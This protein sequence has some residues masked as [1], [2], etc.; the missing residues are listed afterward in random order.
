MHLSR[1]ECRPCRPPAKRQEASLH[2]QG[3][4]PEQVFRP[5]DRQGDQQRDAPLLLPSRTSAGLRAARLDR[6]RARSPSHCR[7]GGNTG[8]EGEHRIEVVQQGIAPPF[9][10]CPCGS[11][12]QPGRSA[13]RCG[14]SESESLHAKSGG[15]EA[16]GSPGNNDNRSPH[17]G[18]LSDERLCQRRQYRHG[19]DR[20]LEM[21]CRHQLG[22]RIFP[23]G[24]AEL[25]VLG[26]FREY[27]CPA[28][29]EWELFGPFALETHLCRVREL[30]LD[31]CEYQYRH[32][33]HRRCRHAV[34]D[35]PPL[36]HPHR[37]NVR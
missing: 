22:Q 3:E 8:T 7:G 26:A 30:F 23:G 24:P 18:H 12:H 21:E 2:A 19:A 35:Q 28:R 32:H 4:I 36:H 20:P 31:G 16:R 1:V 10:S 27:Q 14:H 15:P 34:S 9:T 13:Q 33:K 17:R 25:P 37:E 6:L 5:A 11:V 29:S